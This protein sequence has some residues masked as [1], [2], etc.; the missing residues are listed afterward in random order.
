MRRVKGLNDVKV[1]NKNSINRMYGQ[2]TSP[3]IMSKATKINNK[4]LVFRKKSLLPR[5]TSY[6]YDNFFLSIL[7]EKVLERRSHPGLFFWPIDFFLHNSKSFA[8][9]L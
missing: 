6:F 3:K 4:I 1:F 5:H 7:F 8:A 9:C 2:F